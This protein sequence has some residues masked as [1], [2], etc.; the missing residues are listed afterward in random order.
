MVLKQNADDISA[1][2][3][4]F[5]NSKQLVEVAPEELEGAVWAAM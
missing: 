2:A 4:I 3:T 5:V 1:M